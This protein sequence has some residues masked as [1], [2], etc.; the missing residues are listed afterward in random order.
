MLRWSWRN[1]LNSKC[2]ASRRLS[3][4]QTGNASSHSSHGEFEMGFARKMQQRAQQTAHQVVV[5]PPYSCLPDCRQA[6]HVST[7]RLLE[8]IVITWSASIPIHSQCAYGTR[9]TNNVRMYLPCVALFSS[10]LPVLLLC[11]SDVSRAHCCLR[12][13]CVYQPL[14]ETGWPPSDERKQNANTELHWIA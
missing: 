4:L 7:I 14:N 10:S 5:Y 12:W 13:L 11:R 9:Q 2:F 8:F 6:S 3:L 1:N